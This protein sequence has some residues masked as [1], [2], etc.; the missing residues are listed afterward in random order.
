MT[1]INDLLNSG[2]KHR[3]LYKIQG[4]MFI[5]VSDKKYKN[6]FDGKQATD[7]IKKLLTINLSGKKMIER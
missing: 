4:K 3:R 6:I 1:R 7:I 5:F 2:I